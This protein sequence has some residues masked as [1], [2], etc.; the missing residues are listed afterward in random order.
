M[1]CQTERAD[2]RSLVLTEDE[3][4]VIGQVRELEFGQVL[5]SIQN[6]RITHCKKTEDIVPPSKRGSAK[7]ERPRN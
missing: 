2:G 5:V 1:E 3:I 4:A 7:A 6:H